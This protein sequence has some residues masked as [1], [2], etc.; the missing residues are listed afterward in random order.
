MRFLALA[1]DYDGTLATHGTVEKAALEALER[2]RASG[3]RLLLVT[4]RQLPDLQKVFPR[5]SIFDRVVAENGA[6]LFRPAAREKVPLCPPPNANFLDALRAGGIPFAEGRAIVAT[7]EEHHTAVASLIHRLDAGADLHIVLNKGSVMVLPAGV[8]KASGLAAAL[9]ELQLQPRSVVGIGD[10]ENDAAFLA[11][12]GCAAAVANAL[13]QVKR[14]A[15]LV[16]TL[17]HG[18]G[19]VEVIG[20]LLEND[21][22]RYGLRRTLG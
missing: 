11:A 22:A 2:V 16:A 18:A 12:C 6:L 19:V 8:N 4:G 3:R 1:T 15:D 17:A 7:G 10:A 21:L 14:N 9:A 5:L 13:P 20:Q